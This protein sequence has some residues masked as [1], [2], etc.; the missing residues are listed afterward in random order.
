MNSDIPQVVKRGPRRALVLL[1]TTWILACTSMSQPAP[2]SDRPR[3]KVRE[4]CLGRLPLMPA[5]P[6]AL[7][8]ADCQHVAFPSQHGPRWSV[9][10]DGQEG[11][12]YRRVHSLTFSA[13]GARFAYVGEKSQLS[14]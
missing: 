9:Y 2:E 8:S 7:V 6:A 13:S 1:V 4:V 11:E 5:L 14:N 12:H 10:F 3:L